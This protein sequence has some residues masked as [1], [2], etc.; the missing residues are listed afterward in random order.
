[1]C[2]MTHPSHPNTYNAYGLVC[3][4]GIAELPVSPMALNRHMALASQV[5]PHIFPFANREI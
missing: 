1:M 2:N 3:Y 4:L 5:Y